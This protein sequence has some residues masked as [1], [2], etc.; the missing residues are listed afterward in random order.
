M[1]AHRFSLVMVVLASGAACATTQEDPGSP[2]DGTAGSDEILITVE[3]NNFRD[4]TVHVYWNGLRT[5]A[6]TVIGKSSETFRLDWKSE[7]AHLGVDFLGG[8]GYETETVPVDPGDHLN[9]VIM[10]TP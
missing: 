10:A 5:R 9:F 6:G 7:W 2:F 3:N 1:R 4:A 8:G